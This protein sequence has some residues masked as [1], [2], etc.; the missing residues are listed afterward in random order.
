LPGTS[1][2]CTEAASV[3]SSSVGVFEGVLVDA[4]AV[5]GNPLGPSFAEALAAIGLPAAQ[6]PE[7]G[8]LCSVLPLCAAVGILRR[9]RFIC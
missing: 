9:R 6:V 7:P 4:I 3:P 8:N 5:L 2:G 1:L